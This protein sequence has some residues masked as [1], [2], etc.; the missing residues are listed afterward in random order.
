MNTYHWTP[1]HEAAYM[2]ER[3]NKCEHC[4]PVHEETQKWLQSA[5]NH[6]ILFAVYKQ[7]GI[8]PDTVYQEFEAEIMIHDHERIVPEPR[9]EV[10]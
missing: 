7:Y 4:L 1:E 9:E 6:D 10:A 5:T 2:E 8:T 3:K